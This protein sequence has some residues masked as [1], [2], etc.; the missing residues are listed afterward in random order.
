MRRAWLFSK[1]HGENN[2]GQ[3]KISITCPFDGYNY[4]TTKMKLWKTHNSR[5]H[6]KK[7]ESKI[8]YAD[9]GEMLESDAEDDVEL[10][11]NKHVD[12]DFKIFIAKKLMHLES[13]KK[14]SKCVINEIEDFATN[15]AS[16]SLRKHNVVD[17]QVVS[18]TQ[19]FGSKHKRSKFYEENCCQIKRNCIRAL[20]TGILKWNENSKTVKHLLYCFVYR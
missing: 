3:S 16:T 7:K 12:D 8:T 15:I 13:K 19:T 6:N 18:I 5:M 17:D 11:N 10:D 14:I 2:G 9:R 4:S 20:A 1:P